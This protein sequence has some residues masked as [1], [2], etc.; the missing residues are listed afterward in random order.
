MS[1]KR[2]IN[3]AVALKYDKFQDPAPKVTATGKGSVAKKIIEI[4]KKHNIPITKDSDLVEVLS[5]LELEEEIPAALYS[6]V[7]ELLAFV[8]SQNKK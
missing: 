7:A 6:A 3:K 1:K 8:Y 4:A 2:V 5:K